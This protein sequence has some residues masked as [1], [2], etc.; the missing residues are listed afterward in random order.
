MSMLK[1]RRSVHIAT[2]KLN[3]VSNVQVDLG[4][5][6]IS[7]LCYV[8]CCQAELNRQAQLVHVIFRLAVDVMGFVA[9]E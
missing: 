4:R 7:S 5:A 1:L 8:K 3:A 9:T 6:L 2:V